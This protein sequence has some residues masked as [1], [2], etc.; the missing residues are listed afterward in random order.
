VGPTVDELVVG[1]PPEAW[2][3]AGFS[4]DPDGT[5]RIGAV[6]V[7]LAG[8]DGGRHVR[9]WSVRDVQ[10]GP[11]ADVD[12]VPTAA[13]HRP[14]PEPAGHPNGAVAIDHVVLR[15]PDVDRTVAAVTAGLGLDVRRVRHAGGDPPVRQVFFRLGEV[16]LELIGPEEPDPEDRRPARLWGLAHT[17]ADLDTTAA[18][19]GDRLGPV[20]PAVQA[21]RRIATLRHRELGMSVATAF[22]SPVR[23]PSLR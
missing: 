17:V 2:A 23:S 22:M 20:R 7:R 12:G 3:A 6:R 15:S 4:V 18:V 9:A 11:P 8:P 10:G 14:A 21:G 1:D 5:C 16:V 13:S 19:L